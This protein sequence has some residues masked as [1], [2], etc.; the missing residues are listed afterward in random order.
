MENDWAF[1]FCQRNRASYLM[2]KRLI[3]IDTNFIELEVCRLLLV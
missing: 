1:F 2:P 3:S